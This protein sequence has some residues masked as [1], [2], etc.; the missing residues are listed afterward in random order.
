MT[1]N[2]TILIFIIFVASAWY[3][4][5]P[6]M[7]ETVLRPADEDVS[8]AVLR[9][10]MM[11]MDQIK[12]LEMDFEVGNM[13]EKDYKEQRNALKRDISSLLERMKSKGK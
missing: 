11:L 9:Q 4:I 6:L 7:K 1:W 8:Q 13:D 2:D 12:E 3:V 5:Q 10:K